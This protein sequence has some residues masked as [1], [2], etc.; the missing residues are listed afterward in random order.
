MALNVLLVGALP[1]EVSEKLSIEL[2]SY[3]YL[4]EPSE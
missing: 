2:G 1:R 4:S 3:V